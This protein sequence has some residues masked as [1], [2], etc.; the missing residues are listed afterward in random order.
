MLTPPRPV[1]EDA[2]LATLESMEILGTPREERFDRVVRLTARLLGVRQAALSFIGEDVEWFK[3]GHGWTA[4]EVPRKDSLGAHAILGTGVFVVED[5]KKDP[6]FEDHPL[7]D[8]PQGIRFYA[9]VPL[10]APDGGHVGVL[11]VMDPK[12][13]P[14]GPDD[15]R[16]L[17]EAGL[18]AEDELEARDRPRRGRGD[19]P[20]RHAS[21]TALYGSLLHAVPAPLAAVDHDGRIRFLNDAWREAARAGDLIDPDD[22]VGRDLVRRL[23][24]VQ[25]V[26]G[27]ECRLL[28]E[29]AQDILAGRRQDYRLDHRRG[30]DGAERAY[31]MV[32]TPADLSGSAGALLVRE[33]RTEA[34]QRRQWE[35]ALVDAGLELED[36]RGLERYRRHVLGDLAK[37]INTP[38]TP[39]RL[40]LHL[41]RAG[42][43]GPVAPRQAKALET[44]ARNVDRWADLTQDVL[45]L[46]GRAPSGEAASDTD[47]RRLAE[48]T[49]AAYRTAALQAGIDLVGPRHGEAL[50]VRC[51][52]E[53]VRQAVAEF[54]ETALEASGA[55]DRI[56][57]DAHHEG[58]EAVIEVRHGGGGLDQEA[59]A[60][61]FDAE[62]GRV[63]REGGLAMARCRRLV[64]AQGGRVWAETEGP[65]RGAVF[66]L[67]LP[68]R[69]PLGT[70]GAGRPEGSGPAGEEP[71][72]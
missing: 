71:D 33:D 17:Q 49:V 55:G 21:E 24:S 23:A 61:L 26:H 34:E 5:L 35:K 32:V 14:M 10:R 67:V 1:D 4:K 28:A 41:L 54:L 51:G 15:L 56:E 72:A 70:T 22:A 48:E 27:K 62:P 64:E 39:I 20:A 13:T 45:D 68:M 7:V 31:R 11:S 58:E 59:M 60:R 16:A 38:I 42:R 30:E 57:V 66:G 19:R 3:S 69:R 29:A 6:R 9:A 44:V 25:G 50:P 43:L 40:Q 37:Q 53:S 18:L 8:G 65:G 12:P 63:L 36:L 46:L 2:R 47:L 52:P